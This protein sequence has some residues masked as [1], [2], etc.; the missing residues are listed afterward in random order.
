MLYEL[1]ET[2]QTGVDIQLRTFKIALKIIEKAFSPTEREK[3]IPHLKLIQSYT[4]Y[5]ESLA[6]TVKRITK[7]NKNANA[8]NR[9]KNTKQIRRH[10]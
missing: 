9:V 5:Q 3:F 1:Q 7:G 10:F 4:T 2:I 8:S 6:T